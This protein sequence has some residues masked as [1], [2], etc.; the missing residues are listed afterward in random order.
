M[1]IRQFPVFRE[2]VGGVPFGGSG[3][4]FLHARV[5]HGD[6]MGGIGENEED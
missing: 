1:H 5:T 3:D 4:N 6:G 2:K